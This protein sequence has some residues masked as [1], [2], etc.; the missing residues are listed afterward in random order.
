M[1]KRRNLNILVD[2]TTTR[3]M[4]EIGHEFDLNQDGYY[5]ARSGYINI[6]C[7]PADKPACWD[8]QIDQGNLD[9]PRDYIGSV[10]WEWG[11]DFATLYINADPYALLDDR[12]LTEAEWDQLLDWVQ[13][14]VMFLVRM[15]S[16]HPDTGIKC[17]F[18]S[19]V[20]PPS[21]NDFLNLCVHIEGTH[22]KRVEEIVLGRSI[23]VIVDGHSFALETE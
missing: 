6:W 1:S 5:D 4:I 14:K 12:Q 11:R 20:L 23:R 16:I 19:F 15:A 8:H 7:G 13:E 21:W 22:K 18:C 9:Y 10:R 17:P 2:R 3:K